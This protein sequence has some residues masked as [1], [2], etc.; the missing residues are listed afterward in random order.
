MPGLGNTLREARLQRGI[1]L[2]QAEQFTK[3]RQKFLAALEDEDFGQLPNQ[4][5]VKGFVKTYASYL[6]LEPGDVLEQFPVNGEP[7]VVIQPPVQTA[8]TRKIRDFSA[9]L[10]VLAVLGLIALLAGCLYAQR[11]SSAALAPE[12]EAT[13]A[14]KSL[15]PPPSGSAPPAGSPGAANTSVV[16]GGGPAPSATALNPIQSPVP[17]PSLTPTPSPTPTLAPNEEN[18]SVLLDIAQPV[19]VRAWRDGGPNPVL[20]RDFVRGEKETV[21]GRTEVVLEFSVPNAA[22]VTWKRRAN[23]GDASLTDQYIGQGPNDEKLNELVF[24]ADTR[25]PN[26]GIP[27]PIPLPTKQL[28]VQV[29]PSPTPR[30]GGGG[31]PTAPPP[32]TQSTQPTQRAQPTSPRR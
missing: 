6:G 27:T 29:Q 30:P 10:P 7:P 13:T 26:F 4:V 8:R 23:P 19:H 12:G 21:I 24:K 14:V 28:P 11:W 16:A 18:V 2:E 5:Y 31:A 9:W 22:Y 20:D 1:T 17:T 32:P 3:I 15:G 25:P